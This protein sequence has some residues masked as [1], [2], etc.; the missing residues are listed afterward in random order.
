MDE[1]F[2][3]TSGM[4][5]A[6]VVE[7]NVHS[8][9]QGGAGMWD[10]HIRYVPTRFS[11]EPDRRAEVLTTGA[12]YDHSRLGGGKSVN[13]LDRGTGVSTWNYWE[14]TGLASLSFCPFSCRHEPVGGQLCLGHRI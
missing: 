14:L 4:A 7:W 8:D 1:V 11:S 9:E 3:T 6:I 5:G 10:S 12:I 2:T 13:G